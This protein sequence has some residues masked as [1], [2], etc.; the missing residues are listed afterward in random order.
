M[1]LNP[2]TVTDIELLVAMH[3]S[4]HKYFEARALCTNDTGINRVARILQQM[5]KKE[6]LTYHKFPPKRYP[7]YCLTEEGIKLAELQKKKNIQ[8]DNELKTR[9]KTF[10]SSNEGSTSKEIS[11]GI[12]KSFDNV[13]K[14]LRELSSEKVVYMEKEEKIIRW[15]IK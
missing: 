13:V 1:L 4:K 12:R 15:Y 6:L 9:V 5:H 10:L 3:D 7:F 2:K 8:L 14:T 11:R